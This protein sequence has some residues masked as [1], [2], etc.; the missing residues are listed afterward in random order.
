VVNGLKKETRQRKNKMENKENLL[1]KIIL[2][3]WFWIIV[4]LVFYIIFVVNP[5][6]TENSTE[7]LSNIEPDKD[8]EI[9]FIRWDNNPAEYNSLTDERDYTNQE[10]DWDN[11]CSLNEKTSYYSIQIN[12]KGIFGCEYAIN[13]VTQYYENFLGDI[14]KELFSLEEDG[15]STFKGTL[16]AISPHIDNELTFCCDKY[17]KIWEGNPYGDAGYEVEKTGERI[18]DTIIL[19]AK[20]P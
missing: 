13:G 4:A 14:Q 18:C 16:Q 2:K 10:I 15:I 1:K 17:V 3:W 5:S 20:C 12:Q 9:L 19:P 6:S 8:F 11:L 7:N